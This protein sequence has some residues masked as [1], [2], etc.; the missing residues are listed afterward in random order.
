MGFE[1]TTK[2]TKYTKNSKL[3]L[4]VG[5]AEMRRAE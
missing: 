2:H 4:L 3:F 5:G 1:G